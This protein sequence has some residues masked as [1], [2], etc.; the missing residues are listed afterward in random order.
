LESTV[1]TIFLERMAE[2]G[3]VGSAVIQGLSE[4]LS[5]V[6]LPKPEDLAALYAASGEETEA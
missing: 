1:L 6:K 4:Q 5:G 2:S 3:R